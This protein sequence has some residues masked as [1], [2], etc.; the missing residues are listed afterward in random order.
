MIFGA[1]C[2]KYE[3]GPGISLRSK[4]AR[5]ANT[6]TIT[7][8][9]TKDGDEDVWDADEKEAFTLEYTAKI[10]SSI[11]NR[12]LSAAWKSNPPV[13]FWVNSFKSLSYIN[14]FILKDNYSYVNVYYELE[15]WTF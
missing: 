2:G 1:S 3:E 6:W 12:L 8:T 15:I 5:L 9:V 14:K 10:F 4:K 7:K 11:K 13:L